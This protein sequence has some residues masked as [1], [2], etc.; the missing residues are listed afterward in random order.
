MSIVVTTSAGGEPVT[1]YMSEGARHDSS[2]P[3]VVSSSADGLILN[4]CSFSPL[5]E[6]LKLLFTVWKLLHSE[7]T[8]LYS[9]CC[10]EATTRE[11][12]LHL[13][14]AHHCSGLQKVAV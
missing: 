13:Y 8:Q 14:S 6:K 7:G 12:K 4:R 11:K 9:F 10:F 3:V 1:Y 5:L 2:Q